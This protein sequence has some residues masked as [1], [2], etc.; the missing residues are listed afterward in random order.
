MLNNRHYKCQYG[1]ARDTCDLE[2]I[3]NFLG[4]MTQPGLIWSL[5]QDLNLLQVVKTKDT[6]SVSIYCDCDG[7][8]WQDKWHCR[9]IIGQ[10]NYALFTGCPHCNLKLLLVQPRVSTFP[11]LWLAGKSY[12]LMFYTRPFLH[13]PWNTLFHYTYIYLWGWGPQDCQNWVNLY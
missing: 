11:S 5:L 3:L 7:N 8:P 13:T 9:S 6:S 1:W 12:R 4:F 10:S 2:I